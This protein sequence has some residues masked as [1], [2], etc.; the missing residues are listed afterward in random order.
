[1]VEATILD[2]GEEIVIRGSGTGPID[3]FVRRAVAS[4]RRGAFGSRLLRAF[5]AA[6]I[7]RGG[8]LLNG[9]G[10]IPAAGFS[11]RASNTNIVAASLEAV[12]SAANRILG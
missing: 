12:V 3:G 4:Y 7:E 10:V 2:N 5:D 8:D 1:M 9:G 11:G 6:R